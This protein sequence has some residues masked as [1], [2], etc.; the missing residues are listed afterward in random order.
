MDRA[1]WLDAK[2]TLNIRILDSKMLGLFNL[3][4]TP[5]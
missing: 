5:L 3:T 4:G 2:A 1:L